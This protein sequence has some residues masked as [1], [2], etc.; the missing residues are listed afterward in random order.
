MT[1]PGTIADPPPIRPGTSLRGFPMRTARLAVTVDSFGVLPGV[2]RGAGR[3]AGQCAAR[4][5]RFR[6]RSANRVATACG[7]RPDVSGTSGPAAA[8][9]APPFLVTARAAVRHPDH[10][11]G[12]R[13]AVCDAERAEQAARTRGPTRARPQQSFEARQ[14]RQ[15]RR[16][17]ERILG[18]PVARGGFGPHSW[19]ARHVQPTSHSVS[20]ARHG[21]ISQRTEFGC[22][23]N[24]KGTITLPI[25]IRE[26]SRTRCKTVLFDAEWLARILF[27]GRGYLERGR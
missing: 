8:P 10:C 6:A 25:A 1:P 26:V 20:P 23:T 24:A 13:G 17:R 2:E 21:A 12:G 27:A 4:T 14:G 22:N 19:P 9:P 15:G 16:V 5:T 18:E 11:L 7:F 3:S